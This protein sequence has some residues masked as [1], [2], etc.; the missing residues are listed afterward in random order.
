MRE[1]L[2]DF[3]FV[4]T[5]YPLVHIRSPQPIYWVLVLIPISCVLIAI[6]IYFNG[7]S[8]LANS[9][10]KLG[11][12]GDFFGGVLN[13]IFA[14]ITFSAILYTIHLQHK[15]LEQSSIELALTRDELKRSADVQNDS[16]KIM[17]EQ[18]KT[19]TLQQFDSLFFPLINQLN[20]QIEKITKNE[21][22]S[23]FDKMYHY[24]LSNNKEIG[25]NTIFSERELSNFYIF[26]YQIL[27]NIDL[28]LSEDEVKKNYS[29]IV[30]SLIPDHL[31]QLL[32]VNCY[33]DIE[34]HNFDRYKKLVTQFSI[35]EHVTFPS[36]IDLTFNFLSAVTQ[37]E[38]K[39]FGENPAFEKFRSS[40]FFYYFKNK[41]KITIYSL[42]FESFKKCNLK[43]MYAR[44]TRNLELRNCSG[45]FNLDEYYTSILNNG[46]PLAL[47]L[48]NI[49]DKKY[50]GLLI[51]NEY[52][53]NVQLYVDQLNLSN[54]TGHY[55][56][57][58]KYQ[59]DE[60]MMF[61]P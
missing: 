45:T 46:N 26:L 8:E 50:C 10:E 33:A 48:F 9:L 4:L 24:I 42:I 13:P 35:F 20:I 58:F 6:I 3:W 11:Q 37:Y 28:K 56:L 14:A 51:N 52:I 22:K 39:A 27:K 31:L 19:Q 60:G 57:R 61:V 18:L 36:N 29:N 59:S 23:D 49:V 40:I 1:F 17:D 12:T 54:Q 16:K 21:A 30:R 5:H 2:K 7:S 34:D 15:V 53:T 44:Q 55:I 32:V 43:L 41:E 25:R 38:D 47:S